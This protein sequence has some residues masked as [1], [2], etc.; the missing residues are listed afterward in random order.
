MLEATQSLAA[1]Y[2]RAI[3]STAV[4]TETARRFGQDSLPASD[5]VTATPVPDSPLIKVSAEASSERRAVALAN[6]ASRA[7]ARYVE[8]Q[9]QSDQDLSFSPGINRR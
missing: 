4:Q 2:S 3:R 8:R 1:V 6:T 5:Q 9:G 7:L